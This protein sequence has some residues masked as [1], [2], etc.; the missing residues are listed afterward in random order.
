LKTASTTSTLHGDPLE[1]IAFV[2]GLSFGLSET[3][4]FNTQFSYVNA[5]ELQADGDDKDKLWKVSANVLWQPV[6]QM[7]MGWEVNY[8][9]FTTV[10]RHH[11]RRRKR[12]VRHLV[13]LLRTKPTLETTAGPG[14]APG[15]FSFAGAASHHAA[16]PRQHPASVQFRVP[17]AAE[18]L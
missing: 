1:A 8:G 9:E 11:R 16:L 7:R 18:M 13:L 10:E 4:T 17:I 14:F 5:L 3:T 6:K 2:V 12:H 15:R